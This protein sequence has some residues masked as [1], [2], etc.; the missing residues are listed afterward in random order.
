MVNLMLIDI[1][2]DLKVSSHNF[3]AVILTIIAED[4]DAQLVV[5]IQNRIAVRTVIEV[6]IVTE[7]YMR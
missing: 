3:R 2:Q 7:V 1:K 6:I 4:R 5:V